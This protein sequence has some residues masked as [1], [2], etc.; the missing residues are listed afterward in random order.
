MTG[1]G[2]GSDGEEAVFG[3]GVICV[4]GVGVGLV[5]WEVRGRVRGW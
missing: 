3:R 2:C 4:R 5:Y 1:A